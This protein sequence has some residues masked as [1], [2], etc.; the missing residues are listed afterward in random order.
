MNKVLVR[1]WELSIPFR[2]SN[3]KLYITYPEDNS[4]HR[5][6]TCTNCGEVYAVTISK[7]V[8]VGPSLEEKLLSMQCNTCGI[9]LTDNYEFYPET[10]ISDGV[11]FCYKRSLQMPLEE[12]SIV[13]EFLSIYD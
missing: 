8:Y 4:G 2:Q 1:C 13:K 12:E 6:I 9:A 7:E 10:F 11:K 5:L 3:A